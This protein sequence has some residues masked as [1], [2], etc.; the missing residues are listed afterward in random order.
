MDLMEA[1]RQR[2][3]VRQFT[4][5]PIEGETLE[6]L[7]GCI[8]EC[9][10]QS[11]LG[12]RLCL[13]SPAAFSGLMARYGKF[14]NVRNYIALVGKKGDGLDEACGYYG[15]KIV[16]RAQQ[17]GLNTCWVGGTYSKGKS[18][19]QAGPGEKLRLVIAVGYG[20]TAGTARRG[21]PAEELYRAA[22]SA[23]D[24]FMRGVEAARLAPTA[25]NQQK[26][27]FELDGTRVKATAGSGFYTKVDLG[28]AKYHFEVGAGTDGWEWA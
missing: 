16:L 25:I 4:E 15:E 27:R 26:F 13:E 19:A 5:R 6:Q 1:I 9:N 17:L 12:I 28:I 20:E 24:W 10:A 7:R 22:G 14:S 11:G 8:D 21:K 3:S 23:P 2:H 18:I